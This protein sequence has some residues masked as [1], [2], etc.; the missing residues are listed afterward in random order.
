VW[1]KGNCT[2]LGP[3]SNKIKI[4]ATDYKLYGRDTTYEDDEEMPEWKSDSRFLGL[5][6]SGVD[7]SFLIL[8]GVLYQQ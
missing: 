1:K 5:A 4:I 8:L 6:L 3:I 2:S 7:S